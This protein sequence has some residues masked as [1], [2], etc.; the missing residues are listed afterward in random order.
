[1]RMLSKLRNKKRVGEMAGFDA[2]ASDKASIEMQAIAFEQFAAAK[3][4]APE[5]TAQK[6]LEMQR[7]RSGRRAM[8]EFARLEANNIGD[9][10]V[11]RLAQQNNNKFYAQANA[12][13]DSLDAATMKPL[14]KFFDRLYDLFER[15]RNFAEGNGFTSV[16]DLFERAYAGK[17]AKRREIGLV[18]DDIGREPFA[19]DWLS[20]NAMSERLALM[21][22][23]ANLK[24]AAL[25]QQA[26]KEGC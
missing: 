18:F 17:L 4:L 7:S 14:A 25:R 15:V 24:Q 3:E 20:D 23:E 16:D 12:L 6:F 22:S 21:E 1:M 19:S 8:E 11:L 10:D 9:E 2:M 5:I 26:I 13:I